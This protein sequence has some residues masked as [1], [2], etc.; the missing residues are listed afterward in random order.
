MEKKYYEAYDERYKAVHERGLSWSSNA[1]TPIV[2]DKILEQGVNK[3]ASILEIG[4]GE[5]RDSFFVANRGYKLYATDISKEA[6]NYCQKIYPE[7]KDCFAV[8]DC[9]NDRHKQKYD[10]IYSVA[11]IHMFV[12]DDDRKKFYNFIYEH[13]KPNG[14]ALICSMGDGKIEFSSDIASA[15]E[16][17][18]REHVSGKMTVAGTSCRMVSFNSFVKELNENGLAIIEKGIT[19]ALPDFNKLMYALVK[20]NEALNTDD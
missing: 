5:G 8:L 13:L 20:T 10:F 15:F 11:V 7:I 3:S 6:I 16:L 1:P 12:L 17:Q 9:L 2:L 18:E 14:T 19:E 4:C